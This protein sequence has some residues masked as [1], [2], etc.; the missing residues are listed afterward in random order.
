MAVIA[1][2]M[3]QSEMP[4]IEDVQNSEVEDSDMDLAAGTIA[5]DVEAGPSKRVMHKV[6]GVYVEYENG[7]P[8]ETG[9]GDMKQVKLKWGEGS[10]RT[11]NQSVAVGA[12]PGKAFAE[13]I[14][15]FDIDYQ[16]KK[17]FEISLISFY[18]KFVPEKV[19]EV[20][21]IMNMFENNEVKLF[22]ALES[23]YGE[24]PDFDVEHLRYDF[25]NHRHYHF[26]VKEHEFWY[27]Q[28]LIDLDSVKALHDKAV[29]MIQAREK[30]FTSTP[31][32]EQLHVADQTC[33]LHREAMAYT[34]G[35]AK[36]QLDLTRN[37]YLNAY[38]Y[39]QI[40]IEILIEQQE[41]C[42]Q[43][44]D[45]D[46]KVREEA[47]KLKQNKNASFDSKIEKQEDED[48]ESNN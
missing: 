24:V 6:N 19:P 21:K 5:A 23:K 39:Y 37:V 1:T 42:D 17:E 30:N 9:L 32:I 45:A 22:A 41:V 27:K 31:L 28:A 3:V 43:L 46:I 20:P 47:Q 7:K 4:T 11:F 35:N 33:A 34:L 12:H 29:A 8:T 25:S 10:V 14:K 40:S 26:S 15:N 38:K 2:S 36:N 44:A 48:S 13:S 16:R 18:K